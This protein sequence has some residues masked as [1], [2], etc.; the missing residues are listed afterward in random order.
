M[1]LDAS[2]RSAV[3]FHEMPVND[4]IIGRDLF[5]GDPLITKLRGI[6]PKGAVLAGGY[7]E[8]LVFEAMHGQGSRKPAGDIDIFCCD[9]TA[10]AKT[11]VALENAGFKES[12]L[13]A[14]PSCKNF[15]GVDPTIIQLV[16][17]RFFADAEA[18]LDNFDFT[19]CQLA[20]SS[21]GLLVGPRT[22]ADIA[23][24]RLQFHRLKTDQARNRERVLKYL[25]KGYVPTVE[26]LASL[27]RVLK[28]D[29]IISKGDANAEVTAAA[30]AAGAY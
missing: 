21:T 13:A 5:S 25:A 30:A 19:A 17:G 28:E 29:E 8:R 6:L 3:I 23:G 15:Q 10:P 1:Y 4:F 16:R 12:P 22:L 26:T 27:S 11:V 7:L 14:P 9:E 18:V 20:I 24:K 2:I